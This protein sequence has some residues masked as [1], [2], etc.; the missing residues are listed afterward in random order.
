MEKRKLRICFET[1]DKEL[2]SSFLSHKNSLETEKLRFE[3]YSP[4]FE[5]ES[6]DVLCAKLKI[7]ETRV[8]AHWLSYDVYIYDL[9]T[10]DYR[11]VEDHAL[12]IRREKP[13]L[14][15]FRIIL[16]SNVLT[17]SKSTPKQYNPDQ[18]EEEQ[19]D[20]HEEDG[21]DNE[22]VTQKI[23]PFNSRDVHRRRSNGSYSKMINC[24]NLF[25]SLKGGMKSLSLKII[26]PGMIYG[27]NRSPFEPFFISAFYSEL[28]PLPILAKAKAKIPSVHIRDLTLHLF[29][30][31]VENISE[32]GY[33][34]LTDLSSDKTHKSFIKAIAEGMGSK[35]MIEVS[36]EMS[37][38][39][40]ESNVELL[41]LDLSWRSNSPISVFNEEIEL[42]GQHLKEQEEDKE[43]DGERSPS[44]TSPYIL[45]YEKG[46]RENFDRIKK[47][48]IL[49]SGI[50]PIKIC[51]IGGPCSGKSYLVKELSKHFKLPLLT[52][53]NSIDYLAK[54]NNELSEELSQILSQNEEGVDNTEGEVGKKTLPL[55]IL[56]RVFRERMKMNDCMNRGFILDGFPE[57]LDQAKVIFEGRFIRLRLP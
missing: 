56:K 37:T 33:I 45:S 13:D 15:N 23:V 9:N 31:S 49:K 44:L 47:E 32:P 17:W 24:E 46:F 52:L 36:S 27:Q 3:I 14:S 7:K 5:I 39:H 19:G 18:K 50:H 55:S 30:F 38:F 2:L 26:C 21:N 6:K 40:N 28:I 20:E 53:D 10:A 35:E 16:V 1:K 4:Q 57:T 42:K 25:L 41:S 51:V 34:F 8:K 29:F 12:Y 22:D 54:L 48:W 43:E 11:I